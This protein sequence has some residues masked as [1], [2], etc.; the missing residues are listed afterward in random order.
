MLELKSTNDPA[1]ALRFYSLI[2]HRPQYNIDLI[3]NRRALT[4]KIDLCQVCLFRFICFTIDLSRV[5]MLRD[6]LTV[7]ELTNWNVKAPIEA[8]YRALKCHIETVDSATPEF[9]NIAKLIQSS[10]D[11]SGEQI[12]IHNVFSVAKQTDV[13]NFTTTI[14]HQRQLFHGSK[15]A[16]FLGILSR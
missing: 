3:K 4:E 11:I 1:A 8:K 16:N 12:V 13:L 15:Y 2:P 7:N 14:S 6:M 5:Q 10:T 9:K